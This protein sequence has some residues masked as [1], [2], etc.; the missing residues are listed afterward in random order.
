MACLR[1]RSPACAS[2]ADL[3]EQPGDVSP[4]VPRCDQ[5]PTTRPLP[6]H[7]GPGVACAC[8]RIAHVRSRVPLTLLPAHRGGIQ[9]QQERR[10]M[11]L[12][13]RCDRGRR[14]ARSPS[15]RRGRPRRAEPRPALHRHQRAVHPAHQRMSVFVA[16]PKASQP[17]P[18]ELSQHLH[19]WLDRGD[20]CS[21]ARLPSGTPR[22]WPLAPETRG[23]PRTIRPSMASCELDAG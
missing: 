23:R 15:A 2:G 19:S 4:L 13:P 3:L 10:P 18:K 7:R 8:R 1:P 22:Y 20:A 21:P 11:A 12:A 16:G 5:P 9:H 6:P 17:A 14:P